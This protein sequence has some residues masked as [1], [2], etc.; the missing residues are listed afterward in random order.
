MK[1][2]ILFVDDE[3]RVL[4]GLRRMLWTMRD[5]WEMDFVT[6]GAEA[7]VALDASRYDVVVTDMRMPAMSGAELLEHVRERHPEV[8]R[9][10]L[11]GQASEEAAHSSVGPAHQFLSKP[12]DTDTLRATIRRT[13]AARRILKSE[14][15]QDLVS[16]VGSLPSPPSLYLKIVS[17]LQSPNPSIRAVA[18]VIA[19]DPAMT[20]KVL[21]LVNS[22]FFGVQR[23]ISDPFQATMLLGLKTVSVLVLSIRIFSQLDERPHETA[24]V[25]GMVPHCVQTAARARAIATSLTSDPEVIDHCGAAGLLH[26]VGK[27]ILATKL[28]DQFREVVRRRSEEQI[29]FEAAEQATFGSTHA[30]VGGYLLGLWGLSD[31]VVEAVAFHHAPGEAGAEPGLPLTIVHVANVLAQEAGTEGAAIGPLHLDLA[32]LERRGVIDRLDEWRMLGAA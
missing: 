16:Q 23:H 13:L 26:D 32:Y 8:V 12:C 21:Q 9:L 10:I 6:S 7:L 15:L 5:E 27:L 29:S 3:P 28:P 17:E 25:N 24:S 31:P 14:R 22:A 4:Q 1:Q 19:S 20:A 18:E 11:S 2:R 30:E